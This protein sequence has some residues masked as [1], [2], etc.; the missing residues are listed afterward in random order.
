MYWLCFAI[1]SCIGSFASCASFAFLDAFALLDASAFF[2]GCASLGA[3][4]LLACPD[5]ST[6][7]VPAARLT[8]ARPSSTTV[9]AGYVPDGLTEKQWNDIK[10]KKA[11]EAAVS[12]KRVA[13][14]KF[15]VS[16]VDGEPAV[17][18]SS[19]E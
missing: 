14:K 1:L 7:A 12:K 17:F 6:V 13:A 4:C 9:A 19:H 3:F 15:E 8:V 16:R 5:G 10:N 2:F 11:S 18:F